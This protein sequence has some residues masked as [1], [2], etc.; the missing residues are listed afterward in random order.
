MLV[1]VMVKR[2]GNGGDGDYG[3]CGYS[4]SDGGDGLVKSVL[5]FQLL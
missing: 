2:G 1:V 5:G 3:V 4:S